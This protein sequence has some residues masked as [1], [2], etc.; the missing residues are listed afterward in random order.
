MLD[1]CCTYSAA[2]CGCADNVA[3]L[4]PLCRE[5]ADDVSFGFCS[6]LSS[7]CVS[8]P[9][10]MVSVTQVCYEYIRRYMHGSQEHLT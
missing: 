7:S 9:I 4:E 6:C 3:V 1:Y 5:H 8:I 10:G 2:G